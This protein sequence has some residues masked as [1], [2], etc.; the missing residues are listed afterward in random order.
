MGLT[1]RVFLFGLYTVV[2][3]WFTFVWRRRWQG[4]LGLA[5]GLGGMLVLRALVPAIFKV[6]GIASSPL[7]EVLLLPFA[8]VLTFVG[9][10]IL[11]LPRPHDAF[12]CQGCGYDMGG[13]AAHATCPECGRRIILGR[14]GRGRQAAGFPA[15]APRRARGV[16]L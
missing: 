14:R 12:R 9:V 10:F 2:V 16:A 15:E 3:W 6:P 11:V 5:V 13:H 1:L 8:V 4:W 7:V